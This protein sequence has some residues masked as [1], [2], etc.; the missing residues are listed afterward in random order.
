MILNNLMEHNK[1]N[2]VFSSDNNYVEYLLITICSICENTS[3]QCDFFIINKDISSS[4][5]E[6]ILNFLKNYKNKNV[7]FITINNNFLQKC[8][9]NK[10]N[11]NADITIETYFRLFL[12]ELLPKEIKKIIYLDCDIIVRNDLTELWNIDISNY[13]IAGV[14]DTMTSDYRTYNRLKY[15]PEYNYINAGVLLINLDVWRKNNYIRKFMN[16]IENT[17]EIL[18]FHDQDVINIV[19]FDKKLILPF[20]F[21]YHE[22]LTHKDLCI[23]YTYWDEILKT[24]TNP[25]II[26]FST[27]IKPWMRNCF[28]P[29]INEF[30]FYKNITPFKNTKLKKYKINFKEKCKRILKLIFSKIKL[31]NPPQNPRNIYRNIVM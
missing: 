28:N 11:Q 30:F 3:E 31:C 6:L 20:R 29:Y 27:S 25:L 7:S 14:L 12:T 23:L 13:A 24:E 21:N 15:K 19:F 1:M 17:P 10:E 8:P 22:G 18:K 4:N 9:I 5:K 2:I 26:H 16:V